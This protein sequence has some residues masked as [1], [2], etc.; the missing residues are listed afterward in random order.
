MRLNT[1][2][3]S[4]AA[5]V[6]VAVAQQGD[7][8]SCGQGEIIQY[9]YLFPGTDIEGPT[10]C[11]VQEDQPVTGV[12]DDSTGA[13]GSASSSFDGSPSG[14]DPNTQ[15]FGEVV[16]DS[17]KESS[18]STMAENSNWVL[19]GCHPTSDKPQNV[20]AYCSK[21]MNATESGCSHV[22]KG[23]TEHTIVSMPKSCGLGPY[24]RIAKLE[25]HSDQE[26]AS[27]FVKEGIPA[28]EQ[29]YHLQFDY[30]FDAIPED[31]GPVYMRIDASDIP[32]FWDNIVDS[33]PERRAWLEER[34][35]WEGS[36]LDKRGWW[37]SF[38]NWIKKVTTVTIQ[39]GGSNTFSW[40]N[41]FNLTKLYE[42]DVGA[43][44]KIEGYFDFQVNANAALKSKYG[45]YLQGSVVPPAVDSAYLYFDSNAQA[46]IDLSIT[47]RAKASYETNRL[48]LGNFGFPGLYVP[49]IITLGPSLNVEAYLAGS[50][51]LSGEFKTAFDVNLPIANFAFGK[52]GS[53]KN[54]QPIN[55]LNQPGPQTSQNVDLLFG[56]NG[57]LSVHIV[58][59]IQFGV[60]VLNGKL[61]NAQAF[62]EADVSAGLNLQATV[63]TGGASACIGPY[64]GVL[65]DAGLKGSILYWKT[66][67]KTYT[68][69]QHTF[70]FPTLKVCL[71][72]NSKRD[73]LLDGEYYGSL[74]E[75][76]ENIEEMPEYMNPLAARGDSLLRDAEGLW[77]SG[78]RDYIPEPVVGSRIA[79][80]M[81]AAY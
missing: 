8:V 63:G 45:Y 70:D 10:N 74:E 19:V 76:L 42:K 73:N 5:Y 21:Q 3:L 47:G 49:G 31:N 75:A 4:L 12:T 11:N 7:P 64:I 58:P 72:G 9:D 69:Y 26:L 65:F 30:A 13:G 68:I 66:S 20:L 79:R 1:N 33:P 56:L 41:N 16:I 52:Q 22:F 61:I 55:T 37:S 28:G 71:G 46:H 77:L 39:N 43:N 25:P 60:S 53:D 48:Q 14:S 59:A 51:T 67:T 29:L 17:P 81:I 36:S 54:P 32:D 38:V 62:V 23:A 24:A 57:D 18:V 78:T 6:V 40:A 35:L 2:L 34:G 27:Q 50:L 15:P 44:A 80:N